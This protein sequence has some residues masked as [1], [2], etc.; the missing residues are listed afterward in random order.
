MYPGYEQYWGAIL[1][2]PTG[3]LPFTGKIASK[4]QIAYA[5][6]AEQTSHIV[7]S[8]DVGHSRLEE[9]V[10]R[11]RH[12]GD[13]HMKQRPGTDMHPVGGATR[14]GSLRN[15]GLID[16]LG[17]VVYPIVLGGGTALFKDITRPHE[18]VLGE[19]RRDE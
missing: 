15:Q 16:E 4:A 17:L 11:S 14:V 7:L 10:D 3:V 18:E 12:R 1:P 6:F 8:R 2:N 5:Q 19:V 13:G 9:H